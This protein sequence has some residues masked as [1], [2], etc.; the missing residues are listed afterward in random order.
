MDEKPPRKP[1]DYQYVEPALNPLG[2]PS[3]YAETHPD[4]DAIALGPEMAIDKA[5]VRLAE[6]GEFV[7]G[8]SLLRDAW[9]RLLKNK[10]A[11][12]GLVVVIAITVASL[13]GPIIIKAT[14]GIT[15]D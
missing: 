7:R 8:N 15:P 9:R 14:L 4:P 3:R 6:Q 12:F 10:L 13:L 1:D 2:E 11:V 5:A